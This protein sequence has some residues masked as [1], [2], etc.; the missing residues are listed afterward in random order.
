MI[1]R[2][3]TLMFQVTE[4]V[5]ILNH[6]Y[7]IRFGFPKT[8]KQAKEILPRCR[9]GLI[10]HTAKFCGKI[11]RYGQTLTKDFAISFNKWNLTKR[12][13]HLDFWTLVSADSYTFKLFI[14]P[15]KKQ[16]NN[17]SQFILADFITMRTVVKLFHLPDWGDICYYWHHE[18]VGG[19]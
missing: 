3:H 7:H 5:M 1:S 16:T 13:G 12:W 15:C 19:V 18:D 11:V 14:C 17:F 2:N 8:Q 6:K 4:I 10:C 9:F